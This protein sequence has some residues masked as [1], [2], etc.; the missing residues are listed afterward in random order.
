VTLERSPGTRRL[1]QLCAGSAAVIVVQV[2]LLQQPD[3]GRGI[4][5]SASSGLVLCAV[6]GLAAFLAWL[7]SDVRWPLVAW[8]VVVLLMAIDPNSRPRVGE[9]DD[10]GAFADGTTI[11]APLLSARE[12]SKAARANRLSRNGD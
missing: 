3:F 2:L 11:P 4:L 8:A 5:A 6:F 1:R 7:V 12:P 10:F 9:R